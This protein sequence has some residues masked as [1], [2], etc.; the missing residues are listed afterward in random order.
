M[1]NGVATLAL[2]LAVGVGEARSDADTLSSTHGEDLVE[3]SHRVM[4]HLDDREVVYTV[5]RIIHNRGDR[6]DELNLTFNVPTGAVATGLSLRIG[7]RWYKG[8]LR[9]ASTASALYD[10][11][12]TSGKLATKGPALLSWQYGAE[13]QLSMFPVMPESAITVR[14]TLRAPVCYVDGHFITD[15]PVGG[16]DDT[17]LTSPLIVAGKSGRKAA[18]LIDASSIARTLGINPVHQEC[19]DMGLMAGRGGV[20]VKHIVYPAPIDVGVAGTL[21]R[22]DLGDGMHIARLEIDAAPELEKPPKDARVV[23]VVDASHSQTSEDVAA[24]LE[25]VRA[26]MSHLSDAEF[27]IVVYRRH[28]S[29]AFGELV[30]AKRAAE[31]IAGLEASAFFGGNGSH[32]DAGLVEAV[33]ILD[34]TKRPSRIIAFTDSRLRASL[35]ADYLATALTGAPKG[36]ILHILDTSFRGGQWEFARE[37]GH[38]LAPVAASTGGMLVTISGAE[39]GN[40][41]ADHAVRGLVVPLQIDYVSMAGAATPVFEVPLTVR[42]GD[43]YRQM[44]L[45]D[46]VPEV[47]TVEG[48]IWGRDWTE[49]FTPAGDGTELAGLVFG[50]STWASLSEEQTK[51]A[52]HAGAVVSPATSF[53]ARDPKA[54]STSYDYEYG[55]IGRPCGFSTM[56]SSCGGSSCGGILGVGRAGTLVRTGWDPERAIASLLSARVNGCALTHDVPVFSLIVNLEATGIEIVDVA[57]D[58]STDATM[59]TCV[60]DAAWDLELDTRFIG[61]RTYSVALSWPL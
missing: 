32:L 5:T 25:V 37:D 1:R 34:G 19:N 51:L 33:G 3:I 59:T 45:S 57:V 6:A 14:Y 58:E 42:H 61:D 47:V 31:A 27:E 17:N 48:K 55:M 20:E 24:Q 8:N 9:D 43:G 16:F 2:V 21:A 60:A 41:A 39:G 35:T 7:E 4:A 15:Y 40:D 44:I 28:A 56:S 53:L 23:F 11:L 30:P 29:R 50:H 46:K 54:P 10:E 13:Y 26:Y 12:T 22:F 38:D 49:T 52:G 18:R 36:T